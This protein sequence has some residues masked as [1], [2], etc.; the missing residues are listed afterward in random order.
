[1]LVDLYTDKSPSLAFL[2][3]YRIRY[4]VVGLCMLESRDRTSLIK[5]INRQF[6][7]SPKVDA[8]MQ[9]ISSQNNKFLKL[10]EAWNTEKRLLKKKKKIPITWIN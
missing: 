4:Y 3:M 6:Y 8:F 7:N 10:F 5:V 2:A 1:M 9:T